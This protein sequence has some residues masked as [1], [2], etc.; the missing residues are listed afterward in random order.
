MKGSRKVYEFTPEQMHNLSAI[1]WLYRGQRDRFLALVKKYFGALCAES[2]R[3]PEKV[4]IF[5][6]TLQSLSNDFETAAKTLK[7]LT[8]P[9]ADA[10]KL[11]SEAL[12]ELRD[13][14]KA[15]ESDRTRLL[16]DLAA[17]GKSNSNPLP[18]TNE[19]QHA[20]RKAFDP[21][22]ERIKGLIKQVDLLY[23][24]ASRVVTTATELAKY[25]SIA[26]LYD[27]R[28]TGKLAKQLE[29]QRK[30]AVEQLKHAAYFHRHIAWLQDRFPDAEIQ[31]VP[32]LV[33][34]VTRKEIANADWSLTSGG[35]VGVAPPEVDEDFDFEQAIAE[36]HTELAGLNLDAA[37]L[38]GKIQE[39]FEELGA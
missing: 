35:Y 15:Y 25:E 37:T 24:L 39:N 11:F 18:S 28:A 7:S 14:C 30:T 23:K 26:A 8:A 36:I 38:A 34:V 27:R 16:A 21:L 17:F 33:K 5:D 10:S 20:A 2:S 3:V 4:A 13:A 19:K 22:A 9:D 12:M 31:S 29:E 1:V 32:G 6:A